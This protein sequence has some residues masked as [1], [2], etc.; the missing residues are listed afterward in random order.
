MIKKSNRLTY[1]LYHSIFLSRTFLL[2]ISIK[3]SIKPLKPAV[4]CGYKYEHYSSFLYCFSFFFCKSHKE[5]TEGPRSC[6]WSQSHM[7]QTLA[8]TKE[9]FQLTTEPHPSTSLICGDK[10]AP[11]QLENTIRWLKACLF[12]PYVKA[13][14]GEL[15]ISTWLLHQ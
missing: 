11:S 1:S 3:L 15:L 5:T 10:T 14:L 9:L 13:S 6:L 2:H 7:L 8:L 4:C 12:P